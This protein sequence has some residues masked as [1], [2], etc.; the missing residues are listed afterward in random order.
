MFLLKILE[1]ILL[2]Y[3]TFSVFYIFIF[4]FA[5]LFPYKVFEKKAKRK[6]K[7]AVL[8][9]AYKEDA[10]IF[11]VA[12]NA[13]KQN[14]QLK[15]FEII[16]IADS[17]Q[18]KTI[19]K[20]K[21]L[22]IK[23]IEVVFEKSTKSK[24]LN[25]AMDII[26]DNYDIALV[27]DADNLMEKDFLGKINSAFEGNLKIVQAHR[28]AK[29]LNTNF[30]ILD[31]I[32]EEINN[33]IFRKGHRI[34]G[35]SSALIGSGMA[36]DYIFFKNTMKKIKA[37][38]GFDKELELNF[39]KNGE[40]IEYLHNALVYDEKVQKS[41]VFVNQRR[42][43]VSAQLIYFKRHFFSG[44]KHLFF[45]GNFDYF[46]KVYQMIQI[47]RIILIGVLSLIVF[48]GNVLILFD[49]NIFPFYFKFWIIIW[50]FTVLSFL[51]SI[52]KKFYNKR[53]LFAILI[54]PKSFFLMLFSILKI[55]GANKKFIHTKH[56]INNEK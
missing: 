19:E 36:F 17:F 40:K 21:K 12:K 46:D 14:Y 56:G 23:V 7:F 22:P 34:L 5:G 41:D 27:L 30:S 9:P 54:L 55:K 43:W 13:L 4:S 42:R 45:K 6:R 33:H 51:F 37:I 25:K 48:L 50:V 18:K 35:F 29:N 16:V 2:F 26:G 28:V 15:L 44:L 38:G 52:P 49:I 53:T 32:S 1:I 10:V 47:P 11:D 3:F 24:A 39:L 31:A 8:I 20:L